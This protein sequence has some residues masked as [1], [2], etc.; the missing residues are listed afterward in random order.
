MKFQTFSGYLQKLEDTT[1]RLEI[2]DIL[3]KML[4]ELDKEET[5]K[6]IYL[7]SGY[8]SAPFESEKFNI[9]EKMMIKILENTYSSVKEPEINEKIRDIYTKTG[10]L[11]NV[12]HELAE[13]GVSPLSIN[14]VHIKMIDI[15]KTEGAG[16]QELKI[17]KTTD[18]LKQLDNLSAKFAVRIILGTTRL[19]FTE[20]T[21]IDALSNFLDGTKDHKKAIESRYGIYP[22]IGLIAKMIKESGLKG[23]E[24]IRIETG[25]PVLSQKP[26]RIKGGLSEVKDRMDVIWAEYKFDGTRVQLHF[27]KNKPVTGNSIGQ[28]ELLEDNKS[29]FLINTFTR[30]LE[31]TTH[32]YPDIIE[33][34][35]N[36][37]NA[38]SVILDCE[39]IAYDKES[40]D[41]LP[42]Q[43]TIQRKRK[44]GVKDAA[45]TIPLKCFI[46]DILYLNGRSL[47]DTPLEERRK[48]L[49]KII[50]KGDVLV[51]DEH[52][53]TTKLEKLKD[54]FE[55][56]VEK[57]LEGLIAKNPGDPYQAGAR[58]YSWVKLKVADEKLLDD[59]IDCVVLGYYHGK[60]I[61][62]KFGIGGF[63]AGVYDK[64][65]DTFKTITKVGTGLKDDEWVKLKEMADKVRTGKRPPNVE[66]DKIFEPDVYLKPHIV[67]ELGADEISNSPTHSA[68]YALRFPR[69]LKFRRDKSP[70]EATSLKEIEEFYKAQ[71][72]KS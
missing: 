5:D 32:Q 47:V 9:A 57:K 50:K 19:G 17:K 33:G 46:F 65:K 28:T 45:A 59:S 51:V 56:A 4:K 64:E 61:R 34:A 53:K 7:A 30:N 37:I 67:V 62:S 60:G 3:S 39:A 71:K 66:M 1:K 22:D 35:V 49:K 29:K 40:G 12:A 11:G 68:G 38:E 15:A 25:V 31:E 23:I 69:L 2:T 42:F 48:E 72:E 41:F 14:D 18:L 70:T 8:L 21:I 27:D 10:D 43:E 54:F 58:S 24:N 16:S 36:Q 63:L 26:Q 20:L 44:H 6:A 55:T 52:L 13:K